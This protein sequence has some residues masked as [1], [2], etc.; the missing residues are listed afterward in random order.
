VLAQCSALRTLR[1]AVHIAICGR[2][3]GGKLDWI[4]GLGRKGCILHCKRRFLDTVW[5]LVEKHYLWPWIIPSTSFQL[6]CSMGS[7]RYIS[8]FVYHGT[9]AGWA[10]GCACLEL[11]LSAIVLGGGTV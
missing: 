9:R 10:I 11:E 5:A 3:S 2:E 7:T 1:S 8:V 4:P 6:G